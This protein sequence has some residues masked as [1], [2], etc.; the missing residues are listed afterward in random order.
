MCIISFHF[1]DH[2][3]YKLIVAA[4]RDEFYQR[5]TA[6]AHYWA[7]FPYML[8]GRDLEAMGTWLGMTK[9]GRF[10]ALTNYRDPTEAKNDKRSRGEIVTNFLTG[11]LSGE[12]YLTQLRERHTDYNGFNVLVGTPDE[13]YYYGNRQ[14]E[15]VKIT[16]GTHSLSNHLLNTPWPK[17]K[18][19]KTLLSN[20]VSNNEYVEEEVIFSQLHDRQFAVEDELPKTGVSLEWE[21]QLSPIFIRTKEYGTRAS[22]VILVTHDNQVTFMER[23]FNDGSYKWQQEFNFSIS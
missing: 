16:P 12:D 5:P 7:E 14:K 6:D 23:I 19:A 1:Q 18:R 11:S 9:Q 13:L 2:P 8:G 10:A 20:Y 21:K 3:T 22:T 17:I 4:N 15:I